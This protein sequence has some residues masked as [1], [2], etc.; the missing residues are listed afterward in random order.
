MTSLTLVRGPSAAALLWAGR[1]LYAVLLTPL[2][3]CG[4]VMLGLS[5]VWPSYRADTSEA[6]LTLILTACGVTAPILVLSFLLSPI[7]E[8]R[9]IARGYT[10]MRRAHRE[11]PE[12][13]PGT[14][15]I[16]RPGGAEYLTD[17]EWSAKRVEASPTGIAALPRGVLPS[18]LTLA[19]QGGVAVV[20]STIAPWLL[21]GHFAPLWSLVSLVVLA[22]L[23]VGV[24]SVMRL[25]SRRT[26]RQ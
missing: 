9:E 26:T 20:F 5:Q 10:S 23:F 6:G 11:L 15:W 3:F 4:L 22:S 25:A 24:S 19:V 17:T 21:F 1:V 18:T 12:V 8:H 2:V 16:V 7:Q 14:T 13:L